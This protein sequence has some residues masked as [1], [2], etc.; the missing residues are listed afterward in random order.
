MLRL[1]MLKKLKHSLLV[2]TFKESWPR[3]R[4]SK[5]R[6]LR[7]KLK[8]KTSVERLSSSKMK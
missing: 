2:R 5:R 1:R 7:E 6:P 3:P 8:S 4:Q